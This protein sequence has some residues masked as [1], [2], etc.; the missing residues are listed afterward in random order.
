MAALAKSDFLSHPELIEE[1]Q[2]INA[3][4]MNPDRTKTGPASWTNTRTQAS[5]SVTSGGEE[6]LAKKIRDDHAD[7]F[8][9]LDIATEVGG[10]LS[11]SV[12]A[13]RPASPVAGDLHF[14]TAL[15]KPVWWTGTGW[16]DANG[17]DP[18]A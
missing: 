10:K 4:S 12:G 16:V 8:G 9:V 2:K 13:S 3:I 7:V 18:D 11:R 14:D 17:D 1:A 6:A 5:Y 15:G